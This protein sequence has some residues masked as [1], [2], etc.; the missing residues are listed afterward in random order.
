MFL[1]HIGSTCLFTLTPKFSSLNGVYTVTALAAF[2]DLVSNAN[3]NFVQNL[4]TPAGLTRQDYINDFNSYQNENV[5][6]VSSVEDASTT[7]YFPE[8]IIATVPDPTVK[9]YPNYYFGILIG[10]YQNENVLQDLASQIGE[11]VTNTTGVTNPVR[12][13]YDPAKSTWLTASQYQALEEERQQNIKQ[14][15]SLYTQLQNALS[16]IST[17]QSQVDTLQQVIVQLST[18]STSS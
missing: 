18:G 8:A 17:L 11:M 14:A 16:T 1:P 2:N 3:I 9:K 7:Y 15:D 13:L 10:P 4:Y 12:Y 5:A 6:I